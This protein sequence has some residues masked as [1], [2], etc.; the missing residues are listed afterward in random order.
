MGMDIVGEL[1]LPRYKVC[2]LVNN[3]ISGGMFP[4]NSLSS[5]S[6]VLISV[7]LPIDA[8]M[9]PASLLDAVVKMETPSVSE[10]INQQCGQID[11]VHT[12][13]KRCKD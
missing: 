13:H 11:R 7:N 5:S 10:R 4:L 8:G 12:K 9:A 3:P 1:G 2:V 6:K